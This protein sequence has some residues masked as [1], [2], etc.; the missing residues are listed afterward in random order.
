MGFL[1][2]TE[3]RLTMSC[4]KAIAGL[5]GGFSLLR[6]LVRKGGLRDPM[7]LPALTQGEIILWA[8][9][10]HGRAGSWPKYYSGPIIEASGETWAAID[11]ALRNGKRGLTKGGSLAKLLASESIANL[12]R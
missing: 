2:R 4:Y 10:H 5:N 8:K 11:S 3:E 1:V 12:E 9:R 7:N 6:L